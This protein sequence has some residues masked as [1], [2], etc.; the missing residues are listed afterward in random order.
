MNE[1]LKDIASLDLGTG[2]I[3]RWEGES[4]VKG[5][6][7]RTNKGKLHVELIPVRHWVSLLR[8]RRRH[9]GAEPAAMI[10]ALEALAEFQEGL[11]VDR[12]LLAPIWPVW[13][14]EAA[15]VFD[16]ASADGHYETWNWLKGMPW[17]VPVGCAVR[18]IKAILIDGEDH[19][20]DSG[21]LHIGHFTCNIIM[22]AQY[23]HSYKEGNDLPDPKYFAQETSVE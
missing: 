11:Y 20:Q 14:D 22:L 8:C 17:S 19:D 23:A 21:L 16:W 15:R 7:K 5:S 6:G 2:Q 12:P 1:A 9:Y 4:D 10:V 3:I 13:F 18:H